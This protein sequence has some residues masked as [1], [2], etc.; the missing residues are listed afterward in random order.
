[1]HT[2]NAAHAA[3]PF[4]ENSKG[5]IIAI[6]SISGSEDYGYGSVSYGTMKAALFF[7]MK[8]LARHVA[9]KGIRANVVSPDTTY[10][11]GGYWDD[12]KINDPHVLEDNIGFNPLGRMATPEEIAAVVVF[13]A[14]GKASFVSG[15]NVAVDGT[16]TQRI[17]N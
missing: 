15:A 7:Y 1:M 5:S 16:A 6:S 9:P 10:F 8:S 11:E 13:L 12:V 4:L 14:S 2:R 17:S 3:L